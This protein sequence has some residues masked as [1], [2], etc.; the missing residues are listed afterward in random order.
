LAEAKCAS[1]LPALARSLWTAVY[2]R[3][4]LDT[5]TAAALTFCDEAIRLYRELA[6]SDPEAFRDALA[7]VE[8]LRRELSLIFNLC[9]GG[10]VRGCGCV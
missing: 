3:Q 10:A 6:D 5:D 4:A 8:S 7:A 2:V 1:H 9:G